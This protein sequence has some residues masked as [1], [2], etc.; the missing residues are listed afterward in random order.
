VAKIAKAYNANGEH[1]NSTIHL[2]VLS[3]LSG[4][5]PPTIVLGI[6]AGCADP[7]FLQG[8]SYLAFLTKH[9]GKWFTN[10]DRKAVTRI[11]NGAVDLGWGKTSVQDVE[12][13]LRDA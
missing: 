11:A 10:G 6:T 1:R 4:T 9:S 12:R 7:D 2:T 13:S 5:C 3:C 8:T